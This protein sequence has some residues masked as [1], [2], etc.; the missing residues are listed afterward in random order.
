MRILL[1]ED[2]PLLGD[3]LRAGLRQLDFQVDWVRDGEA[4]ERELR[5]QPY[6]AAILDLG[7]PLKDG[8]P[9]LASVRKA[10]IS[11]PILVL[12]AR[13][14][15]P[16]RIRGLNVGADDYVVKPVDLDELAARLR[17]LIRRAHGQVQERLHAQDVVLDP[18][19]HTVH[20]AGEPVTLSSR[21]FDLLH[22][23]MLNA[24]RVLSREQLEQHLYSW[25]QEV[26]SNAVEVHVHHLRRKLGSS[27]IQTVRGVGYVLLREKPGR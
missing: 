2:D 11:I 7:L 21:E 10:G 5:A 4:A 17:A 19:A 12:T 3:G 20:L 24:G 22:A 15:V 23:F 8:L 6:A 1:A 14:G 9:V 25:G 13:D 16:D 27:L 18:A 26:E